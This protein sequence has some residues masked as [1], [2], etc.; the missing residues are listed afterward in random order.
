MT[1]PSL[2]TSTH[3]KGLRAVSSRGLSIVAAVLALLLTS[4]LPPSAFAQSIEFTLP[5]LTRVDQTELDITIDGFI[6]EAVWQDLPV[7][8]GMKVIDPDTLADT[9]Y[10]THVRFFYTERGLYFSA[11]NFQ[12]EESLMA[13][14]TSR[15]VRLERDG[16]VVGID[17]SGEGLF[18]F[19]LRT[20][21]GNSVTDGT[22]L[23]ERTLNMQWDGP[24]L[25]R[26]QPLEN[27]WSVEYFVPW[28]MMPLAKPIPA[29]IS[30]TSP[31]GS[32]PSPIRSDPR[33]LN[34]M[35]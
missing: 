15:D 13:R 31:R 7:V 9:P 28:S 34:F 8:D 5:Q 29:T 25:A 21:L 27:G 24:W 2:V 3:R 16:F 33:R 1:T 10:E 6:D 30:A 14:M 20:N 19:F 18:G 17:A 12:P 22:I 11:M 26:T 4:A 23:P 35:R 32:I